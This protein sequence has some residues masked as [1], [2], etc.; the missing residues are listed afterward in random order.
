MVLIYKNLT[1]SA[2]A[3]T[4]TVNAADLGIEQNIQLN[5]K[6]MLEDN[7]QGTDIYI[8]QGKDRIV[9]QRIQLHP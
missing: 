7:Y 2:C 9:W 8:G 1:L 3:Q 6:E 5:D 4:L